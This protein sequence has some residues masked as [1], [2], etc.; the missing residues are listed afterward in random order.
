MFGPWFKKINE[1]ITSNNNVKHND[2]IIVIF[3]EYLGL[4]TNNN[5]TIQ[6]TVNSSWGLIK[7]SLSNM[8]IHLINT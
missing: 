6:N 1:L 3:I 7:N 8:I 5:E 2:V 4:E